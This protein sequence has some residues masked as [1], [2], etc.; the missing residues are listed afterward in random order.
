MD[1]REL[2][3]NTLV[4]SRERLPAWA[5]VRMEAR[6]THIGSIGSEKVRA[7]IFCEHPYISMSYLFII[8]HCSTKSQ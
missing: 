8:N 5:A 2:T 1:S 7:D 6:A 4:A 3:N